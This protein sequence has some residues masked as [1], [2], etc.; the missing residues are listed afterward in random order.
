MGKRCLYFFSTVLD[1]ILFILAGND[2]IYE[3]LDEFEI[4]LHLTTDFRGN[5]QGLK[6][7]MILLFLVCYLSDP[8]LIC[9]YQGHA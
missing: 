8:F 7:L 2:N 5:R 1:R 9:R 4:R 3:S 6:K